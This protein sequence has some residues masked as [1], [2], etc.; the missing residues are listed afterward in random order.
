VV[1]AIADADGALK[2]VQRISCGGK[3]PRHFALDPTERWIVCG[4]QDSGT[5]TVFHRD[6]GSGRLTGPLQSVRLDS[7]LFTLFA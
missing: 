4:N 1:Y 7:V 5:V 6:G 3:T 2:P